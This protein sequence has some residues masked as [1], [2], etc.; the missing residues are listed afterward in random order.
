M[1][2]DNYRIIFIAVGLI[3]IL[4]FASPTIALLIKPPPSE[5]HFS[6]LYVLGP[7]HVL[8]DIPFNIKSGVTYSVYLGVVNQMGSTNYYTSY[9]KLGNDTQLLPNSTTTT[10]SLIPALYEYKSFIKDGATWEVP[11]TFQVN[12]LSFHNNI[13]QL[14]G[15]T[16]NG[17]E[18]PVKQTSIWNA[19][20][21]GYYYTLF[22]ELWIFN[23]TL[24]TS[25]YHN[26][27]VS[28]NFNMTQ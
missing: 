27:F 19:D 20:K 11:L 23:S 18:F 26:R 8:K 12:Q 22:V 5:Q 16:I 7:N 1:Q 17:I 14:D 3:G 4:L 9:V 25:Q 15:V 10:P 24:G 21:T 28:L 13:S 2:L 6:E